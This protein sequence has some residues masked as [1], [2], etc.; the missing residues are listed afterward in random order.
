MSVLKF[1][2][3][4][5]LI[6]FFYSQLTF[7]QSN[8]DSLDYYIEKKEILK[9]LDLINSYDK[10][11]ILEKDKFVMVLQF[12]NVKLIDGLAGI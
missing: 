7:G 5:V 3:I 1:N 2:F 6:F 10:N 11:A 4:T 8:A 9:A 12:F